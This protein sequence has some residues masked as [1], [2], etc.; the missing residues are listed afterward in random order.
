MVRKVFVTVAV[1]VVALLAIGGVVVYLA[2]YEP[3]DDMRL[4]AD[5]LPI[6]S[7]FVLA[8][9]SYRGRGFGTPAE[10]ERVYTRRGRACAIPSG[11][12]T[13]GPATHSTSPKPGSTR[14]RSVASVPGTRRDGA[15]RGGISGTTIFGSMHGIRN[16][17]RGC[18]PGGP[19]GSMCSIRRAT[20]R[21][22]R[23][24]SPLAAPRS[25]CRCSPRA[26]AERRAR[27]DER[28]RGLVLVPTYPPAYKLLTFPSIPTPWT[29]RG[30]GCGTR[31]GSSLR[32]DLVQRE[33]TSHE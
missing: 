29:P 28:R 14:E 19:A 27:H 31:R 20:G 16:S 24:R 10:L 7:D 15:V 6:P 12:F 17:Y 23:S 2:V 8:S 18:R 11:A 9:E 4:R 32:G 26:G 30:N 1:V 13:T 25:L 5:A 22:T 33:R 21:P 3:I